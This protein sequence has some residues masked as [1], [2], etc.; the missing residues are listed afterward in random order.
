[1]ERSEGSSEFSARWVKIE[2]VTREI[3][4]IACSTSEMYFV[5]RNQR[6]TCR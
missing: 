2:S 4:S 1:M 3:D 5:V 6:R